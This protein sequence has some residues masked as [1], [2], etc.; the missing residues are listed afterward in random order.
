M[1]EVTEA[2]NYT[3]WHRILDYLKQ[4]YNKLNWIVS[5]YDRKFNFQTELIVDNIITTI[6]L[7]RFSDDSVYLM[8]IAIGYNELYHNTNDDVQELANKLIDKVN[9]INLK[10]VYNAL[11]K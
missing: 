9:N 5:G 11:E 8:E 4:N 1:T 6:S 7:L 2:F 10:D 3:Y